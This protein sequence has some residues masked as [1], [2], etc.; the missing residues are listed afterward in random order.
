MVESVA[1]MRLA[2][3][4]TE[5]DNLRAVLGRLRPFRH[6]LSESAVTHG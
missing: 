6:G 1:A 3:E 5:V 2:G 4:T